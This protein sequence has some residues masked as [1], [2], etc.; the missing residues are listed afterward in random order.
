MKNIINMHSK[1]V[2][3]YLITPSQIFS[4]YKINPTHNLID[5]QKKIFFFWNNRQTDTFH[6][7]I[8]ISRMINFWKK[9]WHAL[10]TV[11]NVLKTHPHNIPT[12]YITNT[13]L[14]QR[15]H[16]RPEKTKTSSME[17]S[18]RTLEPLNFP[19]KSYAS[20]TSL[21]QHF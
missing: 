8:Q 17:H 14:N 7:I 3:T 15:S 5:V 6:F 16:I 13:Q 10:P 19:L 9:I 2:T 21:R 11:K 12:N 20:L 1:N 18:T 4:S